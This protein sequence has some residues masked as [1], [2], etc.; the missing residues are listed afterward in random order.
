MR[1]RLFSKNSMARS[2][3]IYSVANAAVRLTPMVLLPILTRRFTPEEYGIMASFLACLSIVEMAVLMGGVDAVVRAYFEREEDSDRFGRFVFNTCLVNA[4]VSLLAAVFFIFFASQLRGALHIPGALIFLIPVLGFLA[5]LF[6][7]P[8]KLAVFERKPLRYSLFSGLYMIS[9][10]GSTLFFILCL[11]WSWQGRIVGILITRLLAG[12]GSLWY[13]KGR[14]FWRPTF[15][16]T[17]MRESVAYGFPVLVHS[18]GVVCLSS[19]DRLFLSAYVGVAATGI[20][21]VATA[22]V[23]ITS[24]VIAAFG[25]TWTPMLFERLKGD[26]QGSKDYLVLSTY[27]VAV[28]MAIGMALFAF[29]VPVILRVVAGEKYQSAR[30]HLNWLCVAAFFNGLYVAVSGYIFYYKKMKLLA[31]VS[32]GIAG[33]GALLYPALIRTHGPIGAA[34]ANCAVFFIR[35]IT[36]AILGY[37]VCPLPWLGVFRRK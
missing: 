22:I 15:D 33:V 36:M 17:V 29:F 19:M 6:S 12:L 25:F 21:S 8:Q 30:M 7:Y 13:L 4:G 34:Q 5:A 9:D 26:C 10:L 11:S 28:I 18:T 37:L 1:L 35:F 23:G 27:K 14:G 32:I 31:L 24:I 2:V 16:L 20:Y 3:F